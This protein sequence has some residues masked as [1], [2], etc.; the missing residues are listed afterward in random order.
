MTARASSFIYLRFC[1]LWDCSLRQAF[2]CAQSKVALPDEGQPPPRGV[3]T[4]VEM[5]MLGR[6]KFKGAATV[7]PQ[8]QTPVFVDAFDGAQLAVRNCEVVGWRGKLDGIAH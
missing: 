4:V 1:W 3:F 2:F 5:R 8:A 6:V 7:H